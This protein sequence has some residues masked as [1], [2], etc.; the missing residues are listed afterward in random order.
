MEKQEKKGSIFL[1]GFY[2]IFTLGFAFETVGILAP[3]IKGTIALSISSVA[4]PALFII[5]TVLFANSAYK[6]FKEANELS[7]ETN[8]ELMIKCKSLVPQISKTQSLQNEFE[9]PQNIRSDGQ[10]W[11]DVT[12]STSSYKY[13]G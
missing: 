9:Y 1:C 5:A 6:E 7:N 12:R 2:S 13:R 4:V 10:N 11:Q 8:K 3:L